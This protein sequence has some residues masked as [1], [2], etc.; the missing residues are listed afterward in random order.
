[1]MILLE[2]VNHQLTLLKQLQLKK[3]L[4][5]P[6]PAHEAPVMP[7]MPGSLRTWTF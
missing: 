5:K 7:V 1:M 4:A 3:C 6:G 2:N